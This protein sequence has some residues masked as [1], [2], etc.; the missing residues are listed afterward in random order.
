MPKKFAAILSAIFSPIKKIYF[1]FFALFHILSFY[2]ENQKELQLNDLPYPLLL[3]TALAALF[4]FVARFILKGKEQASIITSMTLLYFFSFGYFAARFNTQ[5]S[6]LVVA[7]YT[8]ISILITV[9]LFNIKDRAKRAT[10]FTIVG[11][12]LDRKS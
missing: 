2:S 7:V 12:Y 4:R 9:I 8:L 11:L 1:Y 10:F 5:N 3:T 6:Y